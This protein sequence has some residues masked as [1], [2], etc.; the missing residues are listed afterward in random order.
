MT[1][2]L[3]N[4]PTNLM[5]ITLT[6]AEKDSTPKSITYRKPRKIF[7]CTHRTKSIY[8]HIKHLYNKIA[9][10]KMRMPSNNTRDTASTQYYTPGTS[11]S[12]LFNSPGNWTLSHIKNFSLKDAAN[13]FVPEFDGS[14]M[15]IQ[16]FTQGCREA[17]DITKATWQK[18]LRRD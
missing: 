10:P 5:P 16:Q 6:P 18:W 3:K 4:I 7:S 11:E 1:L 12:D 15:P 2:N 9:T 8:Q 14:N 13:S 17:H